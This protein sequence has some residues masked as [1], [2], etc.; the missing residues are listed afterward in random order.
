MMTNIKNTVNIKYDNEYYG[1]CH[2]CYPYHYYYYYHSHCPCYYH[3][4]YHHDCSFYLLLSFSGTA[5]MVVVIFILTGIITAT[6]AT[7]FHFRL[8]IFGLWCFLAIAAHTLHAQDGMGSI[9]CSLP[10]LLTQLLH[11]KVLN[12]ASP[13]PPPKCNPPDLTWQLRIWAPPVHACYNFDRTSH[14][15]SMFVVLVWWL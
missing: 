14:I 8:G 10:F 3:C 1:H 5:I 15:C 13:P 11:S 9:Q 2:C 4:C 7:L 12:S 6:I